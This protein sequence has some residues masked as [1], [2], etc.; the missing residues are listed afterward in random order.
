[1]D[2]NKFLKK[3]IIFTILIIIITIFSYF[4]FFR[5]IALHFRSSETYI[6]KYSNLPKADKNRVVISFTT[7]PDK[8]NKLRPMLNSL[9][10]QTV[11]VDQISLT[12]PYISNG[13]SYN[14]KDEYKDIINIF[15][16]VKDYG[17]GTSYIPALLREE[18]SGTKIIYL[19]DNQI[20]G[21]NLIASLI[22][23]S[24]K[25]PNKAIYT[26]ENMDPRGG[27]L[28]QTEFFDTNILG[29]TKEN[30]DDSWSAINLN[31]GKVKIEKSETY[32]S[33]KI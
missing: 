26:K 1:M 15:R 25:N 10:D 29:H 2:K 30:F 31:V 19:S 22:E 12:I 16:T 11:K 14:I 17:P 3:L 28:I 23:G 13:K 9:L 7:T 33:F 5:Y 6:K 21:K 18:E 24:N 8:I 4:G 20:Y 32:K 27:V